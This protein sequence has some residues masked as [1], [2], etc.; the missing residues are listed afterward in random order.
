MPVEKCYLC[1]S[2]NQ[3]TRDHVPPQS[4]FPPPLPKNLITLPCCEKCHKQFSLEDEAFRIWVASANGRSPAGD[5][6]WENRVMNSSFKR[7]PKLFKNVAKHAK[8]LN[9]NLPGH[10]V[11][12][13]T[14]SIPDVRADIFLHR[15]TKA[16]LTY[17]YPEYDFKNDDFR[18]F[19]VAPIPKH[20]TSIQ[21]LIKVCRYDSR[22]NGVFDFWHNITVEKNAG[23][24][25]YCFY[26]NAWLAVIHKNRS[27]D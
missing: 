25:I 13:P 15:I 10:A 14:L 26:G 1:G 20:T 3:L 21:A 6:I 2:E 18:T 9:L 17:F 24:W 4:F 8:I 7:S 23:C 22:G 12:V 5:W 16:L 27:L 11:P 19:C